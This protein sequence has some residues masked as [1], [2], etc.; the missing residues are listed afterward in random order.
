MAIKLKCQMS[1]SETV[2][3]SS[4]SL[5]GFNAVIESKYTP[6]SGSLTITSLYPYI[7]HINFGFL[8]Y[9]FGILK[10]GIFK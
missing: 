2:L 6:V 3:S 4:F 5:Y 7:T 8:S 9:F 10:D 1:Y